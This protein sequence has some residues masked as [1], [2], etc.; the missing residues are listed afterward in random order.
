MFPFSFSNMIDSNFFHL[1]SGVEIVIDAL[2]SAV[3]IFQMVSLVAL[4]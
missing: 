2:I 4:F 1:V 3:M